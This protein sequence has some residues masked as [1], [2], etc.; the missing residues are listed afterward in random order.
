MLRNPFHTMFR[1]YE[2]TYQ[3]QDLV[4]TGIP[5]RELADETSAR[6]R[7]EP[8]RTKRKIAKENK[9]LGA[10]SLMR[11]YR[12]GLGEVKV[13]RE[14]EDGEEGKQVDMEG[15]DGERERGREAE[16]DGER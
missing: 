1:V 10:E 13:E 2:G 5:L 8:L 9:R 3:F 16:R 4:R 14:V 15:E 12:E 11:L 7:H 6:K